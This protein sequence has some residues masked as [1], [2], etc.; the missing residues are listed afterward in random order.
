VSTER[1]APRARWSVVLWQ[2]VD[3]EVGDDILIVAVRAAPRQNLETEFAVQERGVEEGEG[4]N[5]AE[6]DVSH[7]QVKSK[8][9]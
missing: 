7:A 3:V 8:L 4:E 1:P 6:V 5:K 2:K 9:N